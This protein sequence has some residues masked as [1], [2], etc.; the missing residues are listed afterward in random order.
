MFVHST[1]I[2]DTGPALRLTVNLP[3]GRRLVV[4]GRVVRGGEGFSPSAH[5]PGF[6]LLIAEESP[7]YEDF[8]SRLPDKT[9]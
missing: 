1:R 6:G 9:E 7:E 4:T 3:D 2:P 8:F 5:S